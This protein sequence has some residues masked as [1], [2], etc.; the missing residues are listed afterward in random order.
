MQGTNPPHRHLSSRQ[1]AW[2]EQESRQW[3][4]AAL[5]D[6][7]SEERDRGSVHGRF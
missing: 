5:I 4:E 6:C 2:L 7:D 1:L 3:Q